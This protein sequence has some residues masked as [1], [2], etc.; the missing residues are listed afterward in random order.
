[1]EVKRIRDLSLIALDE[2][3]TMVIACD[4]CG[5]IGM[6]EGDTL[7][8]PPFYVGRFIARVPLLEVLC[9]GASIV[10]IT[11]AVCNEMEPT[12][13]EII[14]GIKAELSEAGIEDIV[15]T[16]STEDNIPTSSTALGITVVGII[17]TKDLKVNKAKKNSIIISV[18]LPKVGREVNVVRDRDLIGYSDISKLLSFDGV[19]E[20]V[21]VGS[22]GIAYESQQLALS[23]RLKLYLEEEQGIDI[24]KS[25]GPATCVIAAVNPE[26]LPKIKETISNV[27]I[28]GHLR[29]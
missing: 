20:V 29:E 6:K 21:P 17:N 9:T 22:K 2:K 18:G 25:G 7:K 3:R 15:L 24:K 26:A 27:N 19:Y 11:D 23:N 4:S 1:M 12:G 14:K 5:G 13:T 16:G 10:T 28:L 8:I